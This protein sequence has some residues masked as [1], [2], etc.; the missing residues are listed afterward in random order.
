MQKWPLHT[1]D[2]HLPIIIFYFYVGRDDKFWAG[3]FGSY[4]S[5]AV[6]RVKSEVAADDSDQDGDVVES[7]LSPE[8]VQELN[9]VIG[10]LNSE[11][12]DGLQE[13]QKTIGMTLMSGQSS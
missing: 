2:E 10:S 4:A 7:K 9:H 11:Y 12:K 6:L 8:K 13:L 1:A 3:H 5:A